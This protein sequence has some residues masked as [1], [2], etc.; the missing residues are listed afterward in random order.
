M[1]AQ[2]PPPFGGQ[3]VMMQN[4]LDGSYDS[5]QIR[6]VRMAFSREMDEIGTF[7]LQKIAHLIGLIC[8]IVIARL[9]FQSEVL[10]YPPAG[11]NLVPMMRDVAV[12]LSTRWM[13][14]RVVFYFQAGGLSELYPELPRAAR[15]LFRRAYYRANLSIRTSRLAPEDGKQLAALHEVIVPNAVRDE[16][17]FARVDRTHSGRPP[18]I[19]FVGVLRESKGVLV[20]LDACG[21]LH[22]RALPFRLRLVGRFESHDFETLVRNRIRLLDIEDLVDILGVLIG[23]QKQQVFRDADI[24]C[25]P[26]Y[27]ESE[28]FPVVLVEAMQFGLP[29]VSTKWRGIPEMVLD[30]FNGF[31]TPVRDPDAVAEGLAHL[32]RDSADAARMGACGR[33]LYEASYTIETFHRRM[34]EVFNLVREELK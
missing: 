18:T 32:L 7:R 15:W 4:I 28:A 5:V 3:A 29:I 27:F 16:A 26:T 20:L 8:R 11:P 23:E 34:G 30:G 1:V 2:T 22:E 24:F 14:K 12:L 13:F 10:L 33:R 9:R 21:L 19:L 6:H 31:L 25:L 17:G